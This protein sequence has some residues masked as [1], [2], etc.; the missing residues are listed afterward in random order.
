MTKSKIERTRS[1]L[2]TAKQSKIK[3]FYRNQQNLH[4]THLSNRIDAFLKRIAKIKEEHE[5]ERKE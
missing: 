4:D 2:I 1:A 5:Q 3:T